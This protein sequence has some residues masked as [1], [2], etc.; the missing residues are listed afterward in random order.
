MENERNLERVVEWKIG[1]MVEAM[2][3]DV[4]G[5]A[6][7]EWGFGGWVGWWGRGGGDEEAS[8]CMLGG[9][10]AGWQGSEGAMEGGYE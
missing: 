10:R 5:V 7:V 9:R 6:G 2:G 1:I 3:G 8:W 4:E